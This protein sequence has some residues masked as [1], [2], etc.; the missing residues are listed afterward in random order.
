MATRSVLTVSPLAAAA[1]AAALALALSGCGSS[2]AAA[3]RPARGTSLAASRP[4]ATGG[5]PSAVPAIL[6]AGTTSGGSAAGSVGTITTDGTG[7]VNG[8]PDTLTVDIDVSTSAPDAGPALTQNNAVAAAVQQALERDGVVASDIQT[9]GLSLQAPSQPN[10][11]DYQVD[12]SVTATLYSLSKAGTVIDDAI[13]AAGDAGRLDGVNLSISDTSPYLAAARRQAV[14]AAR[15]EAEQLAAAAGDQLGAL[16][17]L[18]DQPQQQGYGNYGFGTANRD[19]VAAPAAAVPVQP[20]TQQLTVEVTGVWEVIPAAT[21]A[22][23][24]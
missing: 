12:D 6:T 5:S 1:A 4:S 10:Q 17:S 14:Q 19:A 18:S 2:P 20:G 24:P 13:A 3:A 22:T 8:T 16:V 15:T 11:P 9:A 21:P 23:A 7:T